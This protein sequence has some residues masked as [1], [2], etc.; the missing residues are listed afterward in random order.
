MTNIL[1]IKEIIHGTTL[2][3]PKVL[4]DSVFISIAPDGQK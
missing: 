1:S 4:K 3:I 2:E